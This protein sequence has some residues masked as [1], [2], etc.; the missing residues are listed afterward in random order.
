[1]TESNQLPAIVQ[2][3]ALSTSVTDAHLV[4]VLIA[5]LGE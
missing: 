3:T 2:P 1:M 4:P 5:D